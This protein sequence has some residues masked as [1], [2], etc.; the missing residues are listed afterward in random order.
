[1]P[2]Y[3]VRIPYI[4]WVEAIVEAGNA[5]DAIDE[6]LEHCKPQS[7]SGNGGSDKLIGVV[8]ADGI[9]CSIEIGDGEAEGSFDLEIKANSIQEESE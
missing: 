8:D 2:E 9:R 4:A 1:M 6:A 7:Y 5:E 3:R